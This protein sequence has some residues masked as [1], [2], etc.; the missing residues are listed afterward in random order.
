ME[1][2]INVRYSVTGQQVSATLTDP[3]EWPEYE[4]EAIYIGDIDILPQ[5]SDEAQNAILEQIT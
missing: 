4:L 1:V 3:A 2:Q 5:L